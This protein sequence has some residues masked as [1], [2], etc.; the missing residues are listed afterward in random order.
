MTANV[1]RSQEMRHRVLALAAALLLLAVKVHAHS[2][3]VI[4]L[5]VQWGANPGQLSERVTMTVGTL[6]LLIPS[7]SKALRQPT[8]T[9]LDEQRTAIEAGVWN[10]MPLRAD[11]QVCSREGTRAFLRE[12]YVE[13]LA[14]FRCGSGVLAQEFKVLSLLPA[15]YQVVVENLRANPPQQ[16]ADA[17][18]H[19]V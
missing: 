14:D 8:Q 13:L 4:Y 3:D 10:D 15:N 9:A 17:D 6:L 16:F 11:G 1:A 7:A 5:Q 18:V 12:G 2:A 19:T